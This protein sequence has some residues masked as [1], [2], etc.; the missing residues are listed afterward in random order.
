MH[1]LGV[2]SWSLRPTGPDDLAD[3]VRAC[4]LRAVQLGLGP[5]AKGDWDLEGTKTAL[6]RAGI[7]VLSGMLAFDGED[8]TTL[9]TIRDTGGVRPDAPWNDNLALARAVA[10]VAQQA[11]IR[12]VT[13]H[14]GVLPH[15]G[16]LRRVILDRIARVV[17]EFTSRGVAVSLETGQE[18]ADT[19]LEVL[20]DLDAMGAGPVGV[21]FDP[22]NM[23]LYGMGEPVPS[24]EQL[25]RHVRQIHIK[26]A[27]P[28]K[29]RGNWGEETPAGAGAVDWAKFFA[30]V[31]KR[32]PRV[33]LVI[34]R[35]GGE[36]RVDDVCRARA[37]VGSL[38]ADATDDPSP[39]PVGVGV[40]GLGFMGQRHVLAYNA[41]ARDGHPCKV[42]GVCDPN[43]DRLSGRASNAGNIAAGAEAS[44][45]L[46]EPALVRATTDFDHLLADPAVDLVSV[47]TYTDTHVGLA[48]RAL[49]AG[50][51]V[52][53]EKPVAT[54][55]ASVERLVT[56]A[57]SAGRVC[58]PGMCMRFWPGWDWLRSAI[59]SGRYGPLHSASFI[60]GGAR[61]GW[62]EFYADFGR[63]GGPM[64]DLHV[65]D[66]DVIS[67]CLG[68]PSEVA[69]SGDR[70]HFTTLYR[71]DSPSGCPGGALSAG[72]YAPPPPPHV[73]AECGWDYTPT[74]GFRMRYTCVFEHATAEFDLM[75]SPS[76]VLH[77]AE[78]SGAVEL[79][80]GTGYDGEIRHLVELL[81]AGGQRPIASLEEAA[82][83][84]R[85][86]EA[87]RE[88]LA[89]GAW[90]NC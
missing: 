54:D 74:S 11:Q 57:R 8:Y 85:V 50:K 65:H 7:G 1:R 9:D 60:R 59:R 27:V 41:A 2:C 43:P 17:D 15:E 38:V 73:S 80:A 5:I 79:P 88:S 13:F 37:V 47:C 58:M 25:A 64:F 56:A 72:R 55:S 49:A 75:R 48:L 53:V 83:V 89:K 44:P 33:S 4:G 71:F 24:L 10:D 86:I 18:T 90:V 31:T 32:L 82:Q 70:L 19:L 26:D 14:A 78:S 12:M 42:V 45:A 6:G 34:E 77:T 81:A 22:A 63:S 23:I 39:R 35:E 36:T 20:A 87:E 3:K 84:I 62:N 61:P 69:C 76:L 21:N 16:G 67:W 51:H 68:T 52:L 28:A 66:V 46:F 40:L 30:V 29:V